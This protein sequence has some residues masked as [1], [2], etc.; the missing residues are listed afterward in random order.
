MPAVPTASETLELKGRDGSNRPSSFLHVRV[1]GAALAKR[2][3]VATL[4]RSR[5]SRDRRERHLGIS[6]MAI[7]L[8][9]RIRSFGPRTLATRFRDHWRFHAARPDTEMRCPPVAW[10]ERPINRADV[11]LEPDL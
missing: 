2:G 9:R 4:G 1:T 7:V 8:R 3:P 6:E 5:V 10:A 11:V